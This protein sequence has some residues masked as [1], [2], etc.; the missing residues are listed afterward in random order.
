MAVYSSAVAATSSYG[1]KA[2]IIMVSTPNG[3]DQLY[4]KT[5]RM[6]L[7]N[8]NGYN[9][10]EFKWYQDL[11]YQKNLRWYKKDAKTRREGVGH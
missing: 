6:A 3:K 7:S 8:E 2:K 4:Y 10:V 5:Y 11:R 9:A 1:D